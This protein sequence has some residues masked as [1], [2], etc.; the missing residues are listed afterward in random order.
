MG[1]RLIDRHTAIPVVNKK[2]RP[3]IWRVPLEARGYKAVRGRV[4]NEDAITGKEVRAA[5]G[6]TG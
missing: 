5:Q 1:C 6:L 2:F 3:D 4:H